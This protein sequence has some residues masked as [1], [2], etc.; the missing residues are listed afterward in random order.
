MKLFY[1]GPS[2]T[3]LHENYAKKSRVDEQAGSLS[4]DSVDIKADAATVWDIL[5]DVATWPT[6]NK[7]VSAVTLPDGVAVDAKGSFKLNG[8]PVSFT[9]AVVDPGRELTWTGSSL[10]TKAVDQLVIER[11]TD[12]TS[13]LHLNESLA[14]AFVPWM[15]SSARLRTQHQ[16]SLAYFKQAAEAAYQKRG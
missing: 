10:W 7:L 12:A 9:F 13:R 16:A 15:S 11:L 8:F 1:S 4:K 3:D 2:L 6:F 5:H 14:G